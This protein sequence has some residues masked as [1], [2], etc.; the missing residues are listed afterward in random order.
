MAASGRGSRQYQD[1]VSGSYAGLGIAGLAL[2]LILFERH[3]GNPAPFPLL[4]AV[5]AGLLGLPVLL[6]LRIRAPAPLHPT[7]YDISDSSLR[8]TGGSAGMV[9]EWSV[10]RSFDVRPDGIWLYGVSAPTVFL[11]RRV[12]SESDL[13]TLLAFLDVHL[14]QVPA[15][16]F[17]WRKHLRLAL[18]ILA[19]VIGL[20]SL[21]LLR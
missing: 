20:L 6:F 8:I 13:E 17:V 2:V 9:F 15:E 1:L 14:T 3:D 12:F 5:A 19:M 16:R 18:W 21:Q 4:V 7:L 11:P 10:F